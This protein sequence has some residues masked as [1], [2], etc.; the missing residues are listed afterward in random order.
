LPGD[1]PGRMPNVHVYSGPSGI[2]LLFSTVACTNTRTVLVVG[3]MITVLAV[4]ALPES[5]GLSTQF[6]GF[7][8]RAVFGKVI[9][10]PVPATENPGADRVVTIS[11]VP[12]ASP[13]LVPRSM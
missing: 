2:G 7:K 9:S 8:L 13:I 5:A 4:S 6:A 1:V 11:T 10:F 12:P 3:F